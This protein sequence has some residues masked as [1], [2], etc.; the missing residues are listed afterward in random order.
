[1][2]SAVSNIDLSQLLA[3]LGTK[4]LLGLLVISLTGDI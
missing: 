1:M 3:H 2:L 4:K